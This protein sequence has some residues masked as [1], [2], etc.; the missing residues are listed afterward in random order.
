VLAGTADA[1]VYDFPFNA[2][3]FAMNPS[4]ALVFLDK[5]F[6][7]EPIAWAIR[8]GDPDFMKFLNAF[9]DRIKADGRFDRIYQ[10]WFLSSDWQRFAR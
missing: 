9:L 1:F 7:E 2:V 10:K 8:K 3:F 5:P 6:T 4:D